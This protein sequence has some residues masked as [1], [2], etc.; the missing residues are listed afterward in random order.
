MCK[1]FAPAIRDFE[2]KKIFEK[3]DSNDDGQI[4]Y[5]EFCKALT[6]G[7]KKDPFYKPLE[8]RHKKLMKEIG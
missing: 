2:T 4:N 8:E 5:K 7:I 1:E 6:Y 3:F